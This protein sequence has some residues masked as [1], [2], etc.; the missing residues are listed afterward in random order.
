MKLQNLAGET[1]CSYKNYFHDALCT[2]KM[3]CCSVCYYFFFSGWS[4]D[5]CSHLV[6]LHMSYMVQNIVLFPY[7]D[8]SFKSLICNYFHCAAQ[9]CMK[10]SL[11]K[12][13]IYS[14]TCN[15]LL[16]TR[17]WSILYS[18]SNYPNVNSS[19]LR[20]LQSPGYSMKQQ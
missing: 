14:I 4:P 8:F 13:N 12:S 19:E 10:C 18:N 15:A 9:I 16:F 7:R 1:S 17:S 5:Y 6:I 20:F 2:K 11:N 3:V